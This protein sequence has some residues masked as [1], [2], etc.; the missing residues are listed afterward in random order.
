MKQTRIMMGMPVTLEIVDPSVRDAAFSAVFEYFQYVDDTFSTY[1]D[2]SEI[3]R[4]NRHELELEDAS[5]DLQTIFALADQT[6]HAP[7]PRAL[8]PRIALESPKI[9]RKLTTEWF[10]NRVE[11]RYRACLNKGS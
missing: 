8:L 6:A 5:E 3:M 11:Q 7:Q 2:A 1:K 9:T 4:L 10:A